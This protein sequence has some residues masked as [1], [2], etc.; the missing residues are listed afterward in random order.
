MCMAMLVSSVAI[1]SKLYLN[2]FLAFSMATFV[3]YVHM[4]SNAVANRA[5][6]V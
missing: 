3:L 1:V 5:S 6:F 2:C 4:H